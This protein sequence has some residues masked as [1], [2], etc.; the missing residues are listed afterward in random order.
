MADLFALSDK[1][2]S[3]GV[4]HEPVNRVNHQ[5]SELDN[6]VAMVE[7]FSHSVV[8]NT[9]DGLVVFDTSSAKGGKPVV[10]AIRG[11]SGEAFNSLVYTHGHVDHVGGSGAFIAA[12]ADAGRDRPKVIC[13]ENVPARF[14]R[15]NMTNG[16]NMVVNTR[17][18]GPAGLSLGSHQN[19]LPDDVAKPDET[20][21]D[22]L[23]MNVGG[24]DFELNHAV[25]ETDDHTWAWVPKHKAICAGDFFIWNFPNAGNPQ[26][27][28]RYPLEWA[29][30]MRAMAAQGA[31]M[32]LPAHGLP[33]RGAKQIKLV[34]EDVASALEKLVHDTVDMMNE[35]AR[36][37]DIVHAVSVDQTVLDKPYLRPLYDEPEFVV[38]N[39]WRL[40]GGWYDGNPANLKPAKEQALAAEICHL[41]G[42]A[43]LLATRAQVLAD[44]GDYRLACHLV[45]MAALAEPTNQAVHGVRAEIY[46]ARR[47]QES[48]L[49]AKGIFGYAASESKKLADQ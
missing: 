17:Q 37:N 40:Y 12:E 11:W 30:A 41:S 44:S 48:S 36:L 49:M 23:S 47:K 28:Q 32:F 26:K 10:E 7:A 24:L 27:V 25:G 16:Y 4:A 43:L 15:Y 5:L 34:L 18:F 22:S 20:Y 9:D 1:I 45:E 13:H 46:A 39:I 2:L 6:N 42:G 33:I 38:N 3:E 19:F 31:E 35:G 8:F 29:I 21:R 14:D